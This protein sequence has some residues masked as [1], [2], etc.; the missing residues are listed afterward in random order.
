MLCT[1][2]SQPG[3][4]S[5]LPTGE[6]FSLTPPTL[7]M[8]LMTRD[9]VQTWPAETG[10]LRHIFQLFRSQFIISL[11][12]ASPR[13]RDVLS[14]RT[15]LKPPATLKINSA[16]SF[17]IALNSHNYICKKQSCLVICSHRIFFP[18]PSTD[19]VV[20]WVLTKCC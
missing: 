12:L 15:F 11:A 18:A 9:R 10:S 6:L 3:T 17:L 8:Y 7:L 20:I 16:S 19:L 13:I 14:F 1:R 4:A 5:C 2:S